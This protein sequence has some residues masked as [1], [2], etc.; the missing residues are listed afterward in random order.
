M[1]PG[2]GTNNFG[3]TFRE[4]RRRFSGKKFEQIVERPPSLKN[5][6]LNTGLFLKRRGVETSRSA[7]TGDYAPFKIIEL[8]FR[9]RVF[10]LGD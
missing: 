5:G 10:G 1:N 7:R 6:S 4:F 9:H 2:P 3:K 8:A